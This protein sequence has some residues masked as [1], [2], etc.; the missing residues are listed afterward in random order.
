MNQTKCKNPKIIGL[1]CVMLCTFS[2][3]RTSPWHYAPSKPL[4]LLHCYCECIKTD[5]PPFISSRPYVEKGMKRSN[6]GKNIVFSKE[7][8]GLFQLCKSF[9][10]PIFH[11]ILKKKIVKR[12]HYRVQPIPDTVRQGSPRALTY[13]TKVL[14]P[15]PLQKKQSG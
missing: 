13:Y 10:R 5:C 14:T 15:P 3:T 12:K 7:L 6:I 2:Y 1:T 4:H 9:S 11:L 8:H